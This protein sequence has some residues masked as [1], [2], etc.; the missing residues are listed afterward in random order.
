MRK[1][2]KQFKTEVVQ[3]WSEL[4]ARQLWTSIYSVVY[5]SDSP[6]GVTLKRGL[7][8][9][10]APLPV[11]HSPGKIFPLPLIQKS[12]PLLRGDSRG[13][14]Q[15][16]VDYANLLLSIYNL[17]YAGRPA[18]AAFMHL[19]FSSG[20][21][22]RCW[23]ELDGCCQPQWGLLPPWIAQLSCEGR[24]AMSSHSLLCCP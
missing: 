21:R 20:F 14:K 12:S 1:M 4:S 18:V 9:L 7:V 8:A 2:A 13:V 19:R 11:K 22:P 17:I 6:L 5:S 24:K 10:L 23:T 16:V 3:R 15:D